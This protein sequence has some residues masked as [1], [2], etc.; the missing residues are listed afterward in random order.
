MIAVFDIDGTLTRS[1]AADAA[2]FADAFEETFGAALPSNDWSTY[3]H[4][5][6]AGI[7]EEALLLLRGRGPTREERTAM[8]AT[9]LSNLREMLPADGLEV[10]GAGQVLTWLRDE[11]HA[12]ALATGAWRQEAELK[13]AA[14]GI[15]FAEIPLATSDDHP[16]RRVILRT[17]LERCGWR[18]E[19]DA[20]YV[21]DGPWDLRAAQA[22]GVRFVGVDVRGDG[23]L[24]ALGCSRVF[25]DLLEPWRLLPIAGEGPPESPRVGEVGHA[26]GSRSSVGVS[27]ASVCA[28]AGSRQE[29]DVQG[30]RYDHIGTGY[31]R[32]RREDPRLR[33]LLHGALGDVGSVLN[34][35]AGAGSYEPTDR[36]VLA[37]EP[38]DVMAA[39]RPPHLSPALRCFAEDLPLRDRSFD[40][41]MAILT[42]HHWDR[43]RERGVRELRRVARGPVVLLTYDP[44]VSG[45]WWLPADYLPE[46]AALDRATFPAPDEIARWLGGRCTIEPVPLP[47]DLTDWMLGSFWAHP[48]RVLDEEARNATSGFARMPQN[49][50]ERVV[51]DVRRDLQSGTWDE[52]Y[53]QLRG[54][55][56]FD[57]GL[58]LIVARP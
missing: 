52:R 47:R 25:H 41:A 11:G 31:A 15:A 13:L 45:A 35:G 32:V 33:A 51:A 28:R 34:V 27:P 40:A 22:V 24:G 37:V 55:A 43:G 8:V 10:P 19:S 9:F 30:V 16:D 3:A 21:G 57:A 5:T 42:L 49:V 38:S 54:L 50:V 36:Y 48:E 56:S 26:I 53:G 23:R 4:A 14:A 17:A 18:S 7:L 44:Q 12:V 39:Q 46:V 29:G 2:A 6:S 20:V 1:C 58:R